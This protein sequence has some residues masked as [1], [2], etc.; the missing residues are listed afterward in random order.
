MAVIFTA[1]QDLAAA[2]EF[3][4]QLKRQVGEAGRDPSQ[5]K[6]MPGLMPIVA[7][8][9]AEARDKLATLQ[10]FT[11]QSKAH[12]MLSVELDF[13]LSGADLDA[14]VPELPL[15]DG[16]FSR[17]GLLLRI[18]K[19]QRLTLRELYHHV[20][21]SRGHQVVTGTSSRSR[22][23]YSTGWMRERRTVSTSCRPAFLRASRSLRARSFRSC[24]SVGNFAATMRRARCAGISGWHPA[25]W[26]LATSV[27]QRLG[28][29]ACA[30]AASN[31]RS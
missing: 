31:R 1:Q 21:S 25:R 13:D 20:A 12:H 10:S 9:A 16:G 30:P 23:T 26:R 29:S 27:T 24:R 5:V 17:R 18:A 19:E 28:Q 8:T 3:Y 14:P 2:R 22:I 15:G 7:R 6:V 4:G 11:D